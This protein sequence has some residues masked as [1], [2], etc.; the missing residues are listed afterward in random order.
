MNADEQAIRK[1][2]DA[3]HAAMVG[4][5]TDELGALVAEGFTL[6]H[7]TG[8]VQP[9]A[10]WF[11]VIRS[12]SFDYHDIRIEQDRL[13]VEVAGDEA[14]V[15]GRGIFDA[16]IQGMHA[17][18]RLQFELRFARRSSGWIIADARYTSF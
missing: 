1:V 7:I 11:G 8:Y 12:R 5:R 14:V 10:E 18:W 15:R 2:L 13:R 6:G 4:A 17:P 16:T 9:K 3:Y